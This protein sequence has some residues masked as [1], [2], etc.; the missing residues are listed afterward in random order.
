MWLAVGATAIVIVLAIVAGLVLVASGVFSSRHTITG[1]YILVDSVQRPALI[2]VDGS[3][4]R[5]A[6]AYGDIA[7][8]APVV[9]RD[10]SGTLLGTTALEGGT[11][12]AT[13]CD[14]TFSIPDVP[15][16]GAYTVEVSNRGPI[17]NTLADMKEHDW[18]FALSLGQ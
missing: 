15:E 10:G 11:P 12:S 16:V 6:G 5:G 9:L 13:E 14:F 4:C 1:D 18:A 7:P 8:G 2:A 17:T 3:S